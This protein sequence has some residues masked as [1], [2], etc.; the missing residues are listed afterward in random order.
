MF[1]WNRKILKVYDLLSFFL[2]KSLIFVLC[3]P[4]TDFF[5]VCKLG[6]R[7]AIFRGFTKFI[8]KT[9]GLQLKLLILIESPNTFHWKSAKKKK[10]KKR[11]KKRVSVVFRSC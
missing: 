7:K 2:H 3:V 6:P 4:H 11:E 1:L 9:T 8:F 5:F 10:K